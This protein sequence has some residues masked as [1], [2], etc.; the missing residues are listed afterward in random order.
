MLVIQL[1]R[2]MEKTIRL[3]CVIDR[4]FSSS[5]MFLKQC[6]FKNITVFLIYFELIMF[7]VDFFTGTGWHRVN[8]HTSM[9]MRYVANGVSGVWCIDQIHRVW[10]RKGTRIRDDKQNDSKHTL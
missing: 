4:L 3:L 8:V 10:Y 6:V 7:N 9:S 5:G 2:N 1:Y